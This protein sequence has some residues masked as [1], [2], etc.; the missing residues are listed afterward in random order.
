MI[1]RKI[2]YYASESSVLKVYFVLEI[3][4][5]NFNSLIYWYM[6]ESK[7][8]RFNV[9]ETSKELKRGKWKKI[10]AFTFAKVKMN[11]QRLWKFMNFQK[12]R[13]YMTEVVGRLI[14]KSRNSNRRIR[15]SITP[16]WFALNKINYN[17]LFLTSRKGV[18][19]SSGT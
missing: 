15:I 13:L 18:L 9:E 16:H 10:N 4:C 1:K 8:I 3:D 14:S 7:T 6:N 11:V 17:I 12:Y 19:S 5:I 2:Q